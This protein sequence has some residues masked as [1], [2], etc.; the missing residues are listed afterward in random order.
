MAAT[1]DSKTASV[2][3]WYPNWAFTLISTIAI[4]PDSVVK[5]TNCGSGRSAGAR[6]FCRGFFTSTLVIGSPVRNGMMSISWITE[7]W[8]S[9]DSLKFG[10]VVGFRCAWCRASSAP[11]APDSRI[12]R[13]S[14]YPASKRRMKPTW[15]TGRSACC[16]SSSTMRSESSALVVSGFSHST[17]RPRSSA[18]TRIGSCRKPASR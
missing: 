6:E 5:S 17:A 9:M 14:W 13:S 16:C 2:V 12:A 7:S 10:G 1:P 3:T 4:V 15:M 8:M 18:V 11:C